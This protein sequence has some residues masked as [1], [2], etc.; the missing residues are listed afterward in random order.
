M[1]EE[2]KSNR[3]LVLF[4]AGLVGLVV[5]VLNTLQ[6]KIG[7]SSARSLTRDE[8]IQTSEETVSA[9]AK[10]LG[11][12]FFS[13]LTELRMY[14]ESEV[15]KNG[16]IDDMVSW[17]RRKDVQATRGSRFDYILVAGANGD[18]YSDI[19]AKGNIIDR[20]YF[21][22]VF[23]DLKECY[24]DDPV[25]S[26]TTGKSVVH[27]TRAV[28]RGGK[29]FAI[30]VGVMSL[31]S[32]QRDLKNIKIGETGYAWAMASN[33]LIIAHPYNEYVM[34]KNLLTGEVEGQEGYKAVAK[35]M[36]SRDF[37]KGWV[38]GTSGDTDLVV[39]APINN[40]PW[41]LAIQIP[42][43][44]VDRVGDAL[45]FRLILVGIATAAI[46]VL[47]ILI[48]IIKSLA[49]LNIVKKTIEGIATGNADLTKRI[50]FQSS[51]EIG[52][53]VKGFNLFTEKLQS[54]VTDIK[55]SKSAL[56]AAGEDL[57]SSTQ[58]TATAITQI[59]SSIK[60][61][62]EQITNQA[63]SVEE[64]SSAVNEIASNIDSLERM[65]QNQSSSV[66]QASAAVE[67]MI[68]NINSV[69]QVVEK[70]AQT[71]AEL[72]DKANQGSSKQQNVNERIEQIK[73]QSEMLGEANAAIESIA[74]QTNLLAMNAAIEASHAGEAGKGFSVVADEIRKLSETSSEQ[75]KTI[76]EQ[77]LK[78]Q[79][80]IDSVVS[81]SAE[82]SE[83]FDNVSTLIKD[84]D[85]LVRQ[86]E[87]AMSEQKAGSGQISE[88]L[89]SMNDSTLE[90][91]TASTEMSEG[92]KSIL[93]E[94]KRLQDVTMG[95]KDNMEEM[96]AGAVKVSEAGTILTDV[97]GKIETSIKH[98]GN[99]IDQFTV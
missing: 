27:V 55:N 37:S 88:A 1:K 17:L 49:P 72:L 23:E 78:I 63:A 10:N 31:D 26:K 69:D 77:L 16:T 35:Q 7:T 42:G 52:D 56:G 33:G 41:S 5:V 57:Q 12:E 92:N 22:A 36:A 97:S 51:N 19:G 71:F 46:I 47:L 8:Y 94:M 9:L 6:V 20:S 60:D 85:G 91:K 81:A 64:S 75:T 68:G 90:V 59:Q 96:N 93:E 3:R 25:F 21:K 39:F 89:H 53:V 2:K 79:T 15:A 62:R 76:G 87:D 67:Q 4:V 32:V 70:L 65:I 73:Q 43:K 74:T 61:V 28:F 34:K 30:F 48:V 66:I 80:S 95:I 40:T 11:N 50:Q 54:I 13:C 58:E 24:I 83:A 99:Q 45:R 38:E 86:I 84:T 98:I 29:P 18:F 14:T 82:S 44:Q